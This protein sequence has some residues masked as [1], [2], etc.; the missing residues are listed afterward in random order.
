MVE[1]AYVGMN[2][3]ALDSTDLDIDLGEMIS[4]FGLFLKYEVKP[5]V[6]II[7]STSSSVSA[8]T[9]M[10]A[11]QKEACCARL[12]DKLE[13][14]SLTRKDKL[15]NDIIDMLEKYLLS[16]KGKDAEK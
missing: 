12:P 2:K 16:W 10:M 4:M 11:A 7:K 9:I 8:F 6:H 3:E 5:K 13:K 1:I 14:N 15:Y